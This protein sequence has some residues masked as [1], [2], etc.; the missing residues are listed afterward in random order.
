MA[1]D[2]LRAH[3]ERRSTARISYMEFLRLCIRGGQAIVQRSQ[4]NHKM[5]YV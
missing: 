5:P 1:R 2:W 4:Y 3:Q